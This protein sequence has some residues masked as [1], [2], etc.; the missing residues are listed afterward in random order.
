MLH[1]A[2]E[3]ESS[4]ADEG[5]GEGHDVGGHHQGVGATDHGQGRVWRQRSM[6]KCPTS[7]QFLIILD[8]GCPYVVIIL[9][10]ILYCY[11][12]FSTVFYTTYLLHNMFNEA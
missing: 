3:A 6:A 12:I 4:A 9:Y 10:I 1:P 2:V 5:V 7:S 8:G 11:N